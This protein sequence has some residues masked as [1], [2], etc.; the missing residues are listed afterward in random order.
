MKA[1][2]KKTNVVVLAVV[3]I[4]ILVLANVAV[5]EVSMRYDLTENKEH[6]LSEQTKE[7]LA[8]LSQPVNVYFFSGGSAED[9]EIESLLKEYEKLS[10]DIHLDVVDPNENPSLAQK[11]EVQSYGTTVFESGDET[12]KIEAYAL[13]T[14]GSDQ[15]SYNFTG[16]QQFTQAIIQVTQGE[17]T[18]VSFLQGHGEPDPRQAFAQ[19]VQMMEGE[20]YQVETLNLAT[21]GSV[22]ENAGVLVIAG[23]TQDIAAEEVELIDAYVQEGGQLMVFLPPTESEQP[24]E[25]LNRLLS[26]W[27]IEPEHNLVID[28]ERSYFNDPLTPI[29]VFEPHT[30]TQELESQQRALILPQSRSLSTQE[31]EG[32]TV[33]PLLTTS[34]AAWGETD[35]NTADAKK[36]DDDMEGPLTLAYAVESDGGTATGETKEEGGEASDETAST[37][38]LVVLGNVTVLDSQLF[39]LQGNADFVLN[40]L[41]WLSGEE[42]NI[43][44][45]PKEKTV[46]PITLTPGQADGIFLATV[47]GL[48][49]VIL[50]S[51]GIVWWRRRKM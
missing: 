19:A 31:V 44:I 51:G 9:E 50:I 17:R 2:L 27:G 12:K 11:Y 10:D 39:T 45:R 15:F 16:E 48:P 36:S 4:G 42:D 40:S 6:S 1:F 33:S 35:F 38:K 7:T 37:P 41:H 23:P 49:A 22:P 18:T 32:L 14:M 46:E 25:N 47:V 5:G 13:Y 26:Q 24:L 43:T 3:L 21:E 20:A 8:Q 28:P 29:P 30:I 34:E